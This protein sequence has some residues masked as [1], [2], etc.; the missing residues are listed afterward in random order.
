[1]VVLL[2]LE[3]TGETQA[4]RDL[5]FVVRQVVA[6]AATTVGLD[7]EGLGKVV[8]TDLF[9]DVVLDALGI[10]EVFLGELAFFAFDTQT[11]G[12]VGVDHS[13]AAHGVAVPLFGNVDGGE[14][15]QVWA[16]LDGGAGANLVGGLNLEGL[17]LGAHHLAL[18]EVKGILVAITPYRD[19]HVFGGVLGCARTQAIGAERVVVV[20]ALVVAVLAACVELAEDEFPVKALF[21]RVPIKR[22]AATVILHLDGAVAEGGQGDQVAVALTCLV[23]RVGKN[24]EGSMRTAIKAVRSED[25]GRT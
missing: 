21:G 9:K 15:F 6:V 13:L 3:G 5:D 12:H 10:A 20:T 22:A 2:H 8:G 16:P 1:M 4:R 14:Y 25:D 7:E 17:L 11:E 18:L 19:V 23:D 24:L